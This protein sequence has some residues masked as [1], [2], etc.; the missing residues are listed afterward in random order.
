MRGASRWSVALV[1]KQESSE[2]LE[3][4]F[5]KRPSVSS[6]KEQILLGKP[7]VHCRIYSNLPLVFIH[8]QMDPVNA[9][10]PYTFKIY[11]N[12]YQ[13]VGRDSSVGITT[14]YDLD[15]PGIESPW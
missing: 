4:S 6:K 2:A 8:S 3:A 14:R 15:G 12:V 7:K 10:S 1:L 13:S 5:G 11:I 9:F